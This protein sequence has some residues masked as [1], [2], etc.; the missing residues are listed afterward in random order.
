MKLPF[1]HRFERDGGVFV[2][3]FAS[4]AMKKGEE[5]TWDYNPSKSKRFPWEPAAAASPKRPKPDGAVKPPKKKRRRGASGWDGPEAQKRAKERKRKKLADEAAR[6]EALAQAEAAAVKAKAS[7]AIM[8]PAMTVYEP[9]AGHQS[10]PAVARLAA[11]LVCASH[12]HVSNGPASP[13]SPGLTVKEVVTTTT[14]T[15]TT[16]ESFIKDESV[17]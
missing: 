17:L 7:P 11:S 15:T 16:T 14:T 4:K 6:A 2:A 8:V 10:Q 5:I 1:K 12:R 3:V 9:I 13:L